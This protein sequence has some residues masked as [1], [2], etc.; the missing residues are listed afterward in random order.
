MVLSYGDGK[1][2][3]PTGSA[4]PAGWKKVHRRQG[5]AIARGA[6]RSGLDR[7]ARRN[8][9]AALKTGAAWAWC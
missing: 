9:G 4:I 1:R 8:R 7:S 2:H 6:M 5:M 3:I